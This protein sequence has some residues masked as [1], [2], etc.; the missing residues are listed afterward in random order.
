MYDIT[1]LRVNLILFEYYLQKIKSKERDREKVYIRYKDAIFFNILTKASKSLS[2]IIYNQ[3][4]R[5]PEDTIYI[6]HNR[7]STT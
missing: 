6:M 1:S 2:P 5:V 4:K 3:W 7:R